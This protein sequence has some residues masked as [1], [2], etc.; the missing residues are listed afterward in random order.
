MKMMLKKNWEF[1]LDYEQDKAFSDKD[2]QKGGL[3]TNFKYD[4]NFVERLFTGKEKEAILAYVSNLKEKSEDRMKFQKQV[5]RDAQGGKLEAVNYVFLMCK[6]TI[7]KVFYKRYLGI[8]NRSRKINEESAVEEWVSIAYEVLT[9]GDQSGYVAWKNEFKRKGA[10]ETFDTTIFQ[11]EQEEEKTVFAYFRFWFYAYLQNAAVNSWKM[12]KFGGMKG[13]G[14]GKH[15]KDFQL[16]DYDKVFK[17]PAASD[18]DD[19]NQEFRAY[20]S[21]DEDPTAS[22]VIDSISFDEDFISFYKKFF[23]RPFN[24]SH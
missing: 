2:G 9:M 4:S 18:T 24:E 19:K 23:C 10:L 3:I 13:Q 17:E 12:E 11:R 22:E 21:Y 1:N 6:S 14:L 15:F 16:L 8:I 7:M 20:K 5:L